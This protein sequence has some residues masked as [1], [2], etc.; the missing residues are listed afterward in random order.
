MSMG[1]WESTEIADLNDE[2]LDSAGSSWDD[3]EA[4]NPDWLASATAESFLERARAVLKSEF[5]DSPLF[6]LKDPRICRLLEFW[7]TALGRVDV[8]PVVALPV[9]NPLE[10][11]ASLRVRDKFDPSIS[12]L[13]W[14]RNVL[15][16][17]A[18]SRG[19]PRAFA[20]YE[21]LLGDWKGLAT[22]LGSELEVAWPKSLAAADPEIESLVSSSIRHHMYED[23]RVHEDPLISRWVKDGFRDSE[24]LGP[25]R[26]PGSRH[27]RT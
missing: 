5:G 24:S 2:I 20:R 13:V 16:A 27:S 19:L 22:R 26:S 8:V 7:K 1:Y 9:R 15:D 14:L 10:V 6:V 3:W 17:E 11:A 23:D 21:D 12:V 4:F 18:G 25:W